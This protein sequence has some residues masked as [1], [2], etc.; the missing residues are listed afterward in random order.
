VVVF[1]EKTWNFKTIGGSK[2]S[3]VEGFGRKG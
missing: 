3:G 1:F 2:D